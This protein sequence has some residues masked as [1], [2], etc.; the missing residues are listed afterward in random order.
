MAKKYLPLDP[1]IFTLPEV[2]RL[3]PFQYGLFA[4]I[5]LDY[6]LTGLPLAKTAKDAVQVCNTELGKWE[7][8]QEKVITAIAAVEQ[9][10]CR[11][12]EKKLEKAIKATEHGK[13][14]GAM[15]HIRHF[16]KQ[17]AKNVLLSDIPSQN[18]RFLPVMPSAGSDWHEGMS[19]LIA[20]NAA[21][22]SNESGAT[23]T[24]TDKRQ[25]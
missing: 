21:S 14:L 8:N 11:D 7:L 15:Q 2:T 24:F 19:D 5:V 13:W 17:R 10:I 3:S 9:F 12:R 18:A 6:W 16:A 20:R 4:R 1:V 23:G 22:Q 25:K